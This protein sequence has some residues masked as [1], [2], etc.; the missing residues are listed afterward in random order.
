RRLSRLSHVAWQEHRISRRDFLK[1]S[2][3]LSLS[4][5]LLPALGHSSALLKSKRKPVF[6]VGAGLA[7]LVTAYIL[8][9]QGIAC[10]L[11]EATPR[12]GGRLFTRHNF[13][14]DGMFC[15]LGGELI[16]TNHHELI[17]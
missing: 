17:K 15:E 16:D 8:N 2:L 7:G 4:A 1:R 11:F 3:A 10:E 13:N 6:I 12:T 9:K 14:R 5:A